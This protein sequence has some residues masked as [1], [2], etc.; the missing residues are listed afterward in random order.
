MPGPREEEE[1]QYLGPPS[2]VPTLLAVSPS[3]VSRS[4]STLRVFS[5]PPSKDGT[6]VCVH[7][8]VHGCLFAGVVSSRASFGHSLCFPFC[9]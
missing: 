1:E 4:H 7:M 6:G 8:G 9:L 5:S 2:G 3:L